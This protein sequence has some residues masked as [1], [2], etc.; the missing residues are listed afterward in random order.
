M[1]CFKL[2]LLVRP[3]GML[4]PLNISAAGQIAFHVVYECHMSKAY[5]I[6]INNIEGDRAAGYSCNSH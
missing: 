6:L 4:P 1:N 3:F 5:S 2:P